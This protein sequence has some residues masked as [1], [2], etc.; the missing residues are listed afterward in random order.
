MTETAAEIENWREGGFGLYLHWP[1]CAA[2]C[3]YCDFNS[4]VV[5]NI[6]IDRWAN[7]Y[8][9][10][11]ARLADTLEDRILDS[12][13]IGGGTPSMMPPRLVE[14]LL[15]A[16]VRR[17]RVANALEI[18]LEANPTSSDAQKFRDFAAVG[19]NRLSVGLQALDDDALR[20]LG[21][22]HDAKEGLAA[23][24]AAR[25]AVERVSFDLIYAR[26]DQTL[27]AWQE[28]LAQALALEPPHLS[29]YQ[30]TI[31]EGTVF[32]QRQK[33]GGLRG[34]PDEDLAVAL[35]NHTLT[36]CDKA[37]LRSY[38]V[39]NF[40]HEGAE[41]RHNLIYWRGGD[42][43]GIGP[44]AH[45]RL[46]LD[47]QRWA[48][49][50]ALMPGDWLQRVERTGNGE[51]LREPLQDGEAA[52]EYLMMGLRLSEGIDEA[53]YRRLGGNG[54]QDKVIDTLLAEGLCW[55]SGD[56][57]GFTSEGRMVMDA[58]LVRLL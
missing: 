10:E 9:T 4:H 33:R 35:Y 31:E 18:T 30:L 29:L 43:G 2:K 11:I 39:S 45:G 56:R 23:Y 27:P 48:T 24:E 15:D 52:E 37:G 32:S 19:V 40:A 21:R 51:D 53:R 14:R 20:K 1:F 50:S 28:E 8:L 41:S 16:I 22:L 55:R 38:E 36:A 46:T 3:P 49:S 25:R 44:G 7:A 54:L 12:V 6:D 13:F 34:L 47:G 57:L 5:E 26:Q 17:W 42:Y 58:L